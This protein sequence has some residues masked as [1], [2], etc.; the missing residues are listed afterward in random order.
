[1]MMLIEGAR[2]VGKLLCAMPMIFADFLDEWIERQHEPLERDQPGSQ[3]ICQADKQPWP[4]RDRLRA[5]K[6]RHVTRQRLDE[7]FSENTP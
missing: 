2:E 1:M 6:R 3:P 7:L 5:G 4:C